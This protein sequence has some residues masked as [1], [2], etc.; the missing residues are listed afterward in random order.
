MAPRLAAWTLAVAVLLAL[1]VGAQAGVISAEAVLPTGESGFVPRDGDTP[2]VPN[3]IPLFES[4]AFKPAGFD[5]P[6][7]TESPRAGVTITRDA[8][9]VPN[10]RAGSDRD[11]WF[12]AGYAVARDRLVQ[13]ELFRRG[14]RG[15]LA[16]VLGKDSLADDIVARRGYYTDTELRRMLARLPAPLRARFDAYADGI[17]AW[18]A[19]VD[20]AGSA[21]SASTGCCR[22]AAPGR[23]RRCRQAPGASRPTPAA[24]A[25]TR[26]AAS[27]PAGA[28]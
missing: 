15:T 9:G 23:W 11:L 3:Q 27:G 22:C 7:T 16:A 26:S 21:R 18:A 17:N 12:G 24:R 14:T 10:I 1:P 2:P 6:G 28:S 8:Y 19:R 13:L 4:F 5:L 20:C 25:P